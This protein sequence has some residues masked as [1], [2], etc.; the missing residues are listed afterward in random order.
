[1][2]EAKHDGI[3]HRI[4]LTLAILK[5]FGLSSRNVVGVALDL[6]SEIPH[7]TV[8]Y[9]VPECV[10]GL[11]V[12]ELRQYDMVPKAD[13]LLTMQSPEAPA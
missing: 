11:L 2:R 12:A 3:Q 8:K 9:I 7:L 5:A 4:P 6:E 13:P 10:N 1:M